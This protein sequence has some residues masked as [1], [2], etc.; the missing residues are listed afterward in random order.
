MAPLFE[1]EEAF[2]Q[3][4]H[5]LV[6]GASSWPHH[7]DAVVRLEDVRVRLGVMFR[8]LGGAGGVRL[9]AAGAVASGHRL[10]LRQRLGL[11][12]TEKLAAPRFDGATVEL[13]ATLDLLPRR[14]DNAALYEWLAAWFAVAGPPLPLPADALQADIARLREAQA[15]TARLLR[16]WPGLRPLHAQLGAALRAQRPRR[17]LPSVEA[18]IEMALSSLLGEF[19]PGAGGYPGPGDTTRALPCAPPLP[20]VPAGAA[21]G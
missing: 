18:T 5:Y 19:G 11:G 20:P 4:W 10:G 16:R 2:G 1:P 9:M 13:P 15:T 7:P 17:R 3:Q 6:G 12:A 21:L 8:A 14:V